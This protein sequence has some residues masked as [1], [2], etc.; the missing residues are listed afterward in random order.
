MR[1]CADGVDN[2]EAEF[3]LS[4][5]LAEAFEGSVARSGGEIEVVVKDLEE[6]ADGGDEGGAV[7][8]LC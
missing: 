6:E 5:I 7:A 4:Q 3:A 8:G 1:V 2:G